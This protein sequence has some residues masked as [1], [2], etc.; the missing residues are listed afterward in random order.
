MLILQELVI[1]PAL[2]ADLFQGIRAPA[3]GLLLYGPPGNY[4]CV[5]W[6]AHMS[7]YAMQGHVS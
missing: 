3:R 2:R 4:S 5:G 7:A 1:L 6:R